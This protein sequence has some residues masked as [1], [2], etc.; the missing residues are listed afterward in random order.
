MHNNKISYSAADTAGGGLL[1][2]NKMTYIRCPFLFTALYC[3]HMWVQSQLWVLS[4][5]GSGSRFFSG[6]CLSVAA[7]QRESSGKQK[8]YGYHSVSYSGNTVLQL[9]Y[10]DSKRL[11]PPLCRTRRYFSSVSQTGRAETRAFLER[12]PSFGSLVLLWLGKVSA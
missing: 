11:Q 5:S 12:R 7:A 8:H 2:C 6:L 4:G 1:T 9:K 10:N 3:Q